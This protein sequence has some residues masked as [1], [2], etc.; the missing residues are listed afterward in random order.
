MY[1][2]YIAAGHELGRHKSAFFHGYG[3]IRTDKRT[4]NYLDRTQKTRET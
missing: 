4:A 2:A 1:V 3:V